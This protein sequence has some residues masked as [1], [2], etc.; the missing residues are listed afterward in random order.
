MKK[1]IK[2]HFI[3]MTTFFLL[4]VLFRGW[5]SYTYLTFWIGGII[6]TLLPD[7]DHFI[8]SFALNPQDHTSQRVAYLAKEKNVKKAVEL[9]SHTR[10]DRSKPVF[11]TIYF[12]LIFLVLTFWVVTSSGTPFG[13]GL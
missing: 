5:Y 3:Y 8:Y 10:Y 9:L 4:V 6:G 2:I 13:I 1:E 12:Q 7:I 11:H